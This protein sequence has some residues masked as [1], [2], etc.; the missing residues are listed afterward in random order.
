VEVPKDIAALGP[1]FPKGVDYYIDT[2]IGYRE[3][4]FGMWHAGF[5]SERTY[6]LRDELLECLKCR[7]FR[8][9]EINIDRPNISVLLRPATRAEYD[10]WRKLNS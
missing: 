10:E 1:L 6:G 2:F 3:R 9:A 5:K 4:Y 8:Y 7:G